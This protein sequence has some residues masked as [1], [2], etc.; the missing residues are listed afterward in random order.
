MQ[1]DFPST[2]NFV[3]ADTV[4]AV[5]VVA[6]LITT[7]ILGWFILLPDEYK[8]LGKQVF[9]GS[10]YTNNLLLFRE[11]SSYFDTK[12]NADPLLHLWSL[13]V[14]EQFY[15]VF[16]L[17]LWCAFRTKRYFLFVISVL[18]LLSFVLS[19]TDNSMAPPRFADV[20]FLKVHP[21]IS[22]LEISP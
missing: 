5:S 14:E 8:Y 9:G 13:G 11:S 7:L 22:N 16:P 20:Q 1:S 18:T 15:L 2:T 21:S 6:V 17:L 3:S 19:L 12:S 10:S 4:Y